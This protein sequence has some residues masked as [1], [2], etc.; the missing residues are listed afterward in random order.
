MEAVCDAVVVEQVPARGDDHLVVGDLVETHGAA[1]VALGTAHR[2]GRAKP[3]GRGG[4]L[5][6]SLNSKE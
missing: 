2:A 3:N 4:A 1:A 6:Y 5:L